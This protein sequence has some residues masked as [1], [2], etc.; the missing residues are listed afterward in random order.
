MQ[1]YDLQARESYYQQ[2]LLKNPNHRTAHLWLA[3]NFTVQGKF[4]EAEREILRVQELD[5]LSFGV[6]MHLSELYYYWRKPDQS[7]EQAEVMLAANPENKGVY[8]FL[9]KAYAQKGEFD[10]AFAALEKNPTDDVNR[11]Y[12]LA[13][14]GRVDEARNIVEAVAKSEPGNKNPYCV[15]AM[16]AALGER[17]KAFAWLEKSYAVRQADLVSIKIDP[18]LDN[19]RDDERYRDLLQRVHLTE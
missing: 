16:Y 2:A 12:I 5:P 6:R 7:L 19:V 8:S 18:P 9:A 13:L 15:G 4:E 17:E 1:N 10:K 3:N 11:V 14:A